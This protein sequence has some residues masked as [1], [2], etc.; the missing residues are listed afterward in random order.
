VSDLTDRFLA[1]APAGR[2]DRFGER[3]DLMSVQR[4]LKALGTFGHQIA[5]A[6]RQGFASAVP[7]TLRYLRRTLSDHARFAELY[8]LLLPHLPELRQ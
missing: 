2:S 6:N 3:F 5:V 8:G 4:H 7:R 1:A